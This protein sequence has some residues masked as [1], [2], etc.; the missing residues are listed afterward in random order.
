[1]LLIISFIKKPSNRQKADTQRLFLCPSICPFLP[2]PYNIFSFLHNG[3][4][5]QKLLNFLTL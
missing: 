2:F 3:V 1:M 5:N 4:F